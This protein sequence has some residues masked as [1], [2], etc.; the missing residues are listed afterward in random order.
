MDIYNLRKGHKF[1]EILKFIYAYNRCVE[2]KEGQVGIALNQDAIAKYLK[3]SRRHLIRHFN[4]MK[5]NGFITIVDKIHFKG[6]KKFR[7]S[8]NIWYANLYSVDDEAIRN[9]LIYTTGEDIEEHIKEESL[10]YFDFITHV[11]AEYQAKLKGKDLTDEEVSTIKD[12]VKKSMEDKEKR[13]QAKIDK[14]KIENAKYL[15]MLDKINKDSSIKMNYLAENKKRLT[16]EIC[17]TMN[18]DKHSIETW[19]RNERERLLKKYFDTDKE[20]VEF[21]TNAS[22]YRL[23]YSL[24]HNCTTPHEEGTDIYELIYNECGFDIKWSDKL[25]NEF[26]KLLMPIYM[27]EWVISYRCSEFNRQ[28]KW[29]TFYSKTVEKGYLFY[30]QFVDLFK[31]DLKDIL[32]TIRAAM[33]KVFNLAKFYM[34]DI[35]IHESNLHILMIKKFKD[36]EIKTINVYDGFYFIKGTMTRELYDK[37]YDECVLE[38]LEDY[39]A[40]GVVCFD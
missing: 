21:D 1:P 33:H 34:A 16:N 20:V 25:R 31:R 39:K 30:K 29:K 40:R 9:Y 22:I 38:L 23:S 26:K 18:P 27:R 2:I 5:E 36:M 13:E 32:T 14:M 28:S 6:D 24:G 35:F 4:V 15:N 11:K 37:I 7:A 19:G 12:S 3:M 10:R 17:T 8:K